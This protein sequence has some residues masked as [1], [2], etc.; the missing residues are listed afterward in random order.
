VSTNTTNYNLVKPTKATDYVDID[1]INANM[2]IIDVALEG[3][4]DKVAGKQLSTEDFTTTEKTKLSG[5]EA[6]ANNYSHPANHPPSIITQDTNNRF[7]TDAEKTAWNAKA[8]NS[9]LT[10]HLADNVAHVTAAER[11]T[12]NAKQSADATL[13]KFK[14]GSSTYTDNDTAQTFADAFCT[15]ASLV[16]ISI[17]SGTAPQGIWTVNS[18]AGSFTITSTVAESN[19][20]T[21]DYY[22]QKVV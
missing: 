17:T 11:T 16:T 19:D 21:F 2:D 4:V 15:A 13:A 12:W 5:I 20:I 3:K 7:T 9:A 14:S 6:G 18:A 1:V 8:D 22:I 10:A